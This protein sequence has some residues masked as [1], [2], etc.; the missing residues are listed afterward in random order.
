MHKASRRHFLKE[1]EA[2]KVLTDF[3][4]A[5]DA[6]PEELFG[7]KPR[8]ELL[9]TQQAKIFIFNDVPF[10][11]KIQDSLFPTLLFKAALSLLP[12]V[13]LDMGAIPHICNGAD[14]MAPGVVKIDGEFDEDDFILV[15]DKK[16]GKPLAIGK[17][18]FDSETMKT[19]KT[20]KVAKNLHYVGDK[21]WNLSK[22]L[23]E[24]R[25]G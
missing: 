21:I 19:T 6:E 24:K 3:C 25:K 16:Y 11:A 4:K 22:N 8:V 18:L 15:V 1:S 23:A 12:K 9:E 13:V 17:A 7:P 20:G 2:K 10:S 14:I 5:L